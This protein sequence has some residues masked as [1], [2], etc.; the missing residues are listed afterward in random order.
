[1]LPYIPENATLV[2]KVL[3]VNIFLFMGYKDTLSQCLYYYDFTD[4]QF[5]YKL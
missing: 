1:M 4:K 3:I 2:D 5:I